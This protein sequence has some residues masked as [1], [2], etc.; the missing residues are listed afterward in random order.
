MLCI[1]I[2]TM[3][4]GKYL[5][6]F[7]LFPWYLEKGSTSWSRTLTKCKLLC[8]WLCSSP[9]KAYRGHITTLYCIHIQRLFIWTCTFT[10]FSIIWFDLLVCS[11][12]TLILNYICFVSNM[13]E[14]AAWSTI[15]K[16]IYIYISIDIYI[17]I[18]KLN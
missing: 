16:H 8:S 4:N 3:W 14:C 10:R 5:V 17:I 18:D 12:R 13:G 9:M 11:E 1:H 6:K 7:V 2:Y 15:Y